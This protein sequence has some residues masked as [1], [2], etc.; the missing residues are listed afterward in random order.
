MRHVTTT[1]TTPQ[2]LEVLRYGSPGAYQW[3]IHYTATLPIPQTPYEI[4]LDLFFDAP[5]VPVT[6]VKAVIP[7]YLSPTITKLVP[8][9]IG[10]DTYKWFHPFTGKLVS[11]DS[12]PTFDMKKLNTDC[13][14]LWAENSASKR[15]QD[16]LVCLSK[17]GCSK[18]CLNLAD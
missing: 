16:E 15:G 11:T 8:D 9:V 7:T 17:Q 10:A 18:A 3:R 2:S 1:T 6:V 13:I 4:F 12:A 5:L 14:V